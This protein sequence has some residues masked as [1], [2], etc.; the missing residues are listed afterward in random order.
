MLAAALLGVALVP[1][2]L[3]HRAARLPHRTAIFA[4]SAEEEAY[5]AGESAVSTFMRP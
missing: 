5:A 1:T 2:P 4:A 3:V